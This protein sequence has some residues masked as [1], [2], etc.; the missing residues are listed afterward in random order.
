MPEL[1]PPP[2]V[3]PES[4]RALF[5]S[6]ADFAAYAPWRFAYDS[7]VVGLIDPV[8]GETRIAS[9]LGNAGEVFAAVIY[10]RPSGITWI[11]RML[12][13]QPDPD[14]LDPI[15]GMDC[16][17]LEFVPKRELWE[18]DMALL[19][20]IDFKPVGRGS[21]WP[22]FRSSESGWHPWFINQKEAD[23]LLADLPRLEAFCKLLEAQPEAFEDRAPTDIPFIPV[24]LPERPLTPEDIDWRPML[25]PPVPGLDLHKATA[26]TV[27]RL[28]TLH[29]AR[30]TAC[31]FETTILPGGSFVE[32]GRPCFGRFSLL[33][34]AETGAVTG[35]DVASATVSAGEATIE[36][37]TKALTT[38]GCL[39]DIIHV[40][41]TRLFP[42]LAPF[43]EALEIQLESASSLPG[44][45]EALAS[46]AAHLLNER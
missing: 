9:V 24:T 41:G 36:A 29:R 21:V 25:P 16:L 34:D 23:Q 28:G 11:L 4:W 6:A 35:M 14:R 8:T 20:A 15:E 31:E 18:E 3:A 38:A 13:D 27:E 19:K 45:E 2:T 32:D 46:L 43:C 12:S 22:Q 33:V 7:D 30:G 44:V 1:A 10:R 17:K 37:L 40:S 39:P 26:E 42:V 5:A